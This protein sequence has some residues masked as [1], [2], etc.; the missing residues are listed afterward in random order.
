MKKIIVVFS[1]IAVIIGLFLMVT[2]GKVF[3][4]GYFS[5]V[6]ESWSDI[7]QREYA[8]ILFS[9]GLLQ[10]SSV[11]Y[12][13][14]IEKSSLPKKELAAVCYKLGNIYMD[15]NEYGKALSNFY[16]VELL[17]A[18]PA[19]KQEMSRRIVEALEN[20]GLKQ[21]AQ[22]EL[23]SR[24]SLGAV[25]K[26]EGKVIARIGKRQISMAEIDQVLSILPEQLQKSVRDDNSKLGVFIKNYVNTEVL[27]EEAKKLGLERNSKVR[28]ALDNY[29]KEFI[30]QEMI[31][32]HIA[33]NIKITPQDVELYYKANKEKYATSEKIKVSY[34]E[35]NAI[36]QKIDTVNKLRSGLGKKID[37]WIEKTYPGIPS[38]GGKKEN[39]AELFLLEKNGV[40][41]PVVIKDK[42]YLFLVEDK[43]LSRQMSFEEAHERAEY[44]Y[45]L[46][47][48]QEAVNELLQKALEQQEV[49][50]YFNAKNNEKD[51]SDKK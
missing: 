29:K 37:E 27:Y 5:K 42:L 20:L 39:V 41:E 11:A 30:L 17:D 50:M 40:S 18:S 25:E 45:R 15:L 44:E 49:E 2:G 32:E 38:L 4:T 19:Y 24:T 7:L 23:D 22:Y 14:Y 36:E 3:N 13:N 35:L 28:A 48:E 31:L 34:L 8:N 51:E 26:P 16:K 9:K 10:E 33:K 12:E 21:Q 46:K 47:K 1:I 6:S 43:E